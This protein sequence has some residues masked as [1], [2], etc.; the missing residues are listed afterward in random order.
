VSKC[1][2]VHTSVSSDVIQHH[3]SFKLTLKAA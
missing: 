3:K 2:I 1:D